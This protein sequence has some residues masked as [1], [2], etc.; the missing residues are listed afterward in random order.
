ML[1]CAAVWWRH[2]SWLVGVAVLALTVPYLHLYALNQALMN[3]AGDRFA[4]TVD[5]V[6]VLL[7]WLCLAVAA[8]RSTPA[9]TPDVQE[10]AELEA[11][12]GGVD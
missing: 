11:V 12:R 1:V 8:L 6:A 3:I 2:R 4:S 10:A 5:G 9:R 7:A